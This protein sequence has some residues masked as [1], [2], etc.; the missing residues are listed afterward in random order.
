MAEPTLKFNNVKTALNSRNSKGATNYQSKKYPTAY[1]L[2][3]TLAELPDSLSDNALIFTTD[4]AELFVG[5][6]S[7]I[8]RLKLGTE[9]DLNPR[10]YL[11]ILE[12]KEIYK[13]KLEAEQ[14][15]AELQSLIQ[16]LKDSVYSKADID[17]FITKD[18]DLDGVIDKLN[19]Y[20]VEK[21]NQLLEQE[22]SRA[23]V[24]TQTQV[25][26]KVD[27]AKQEASDAVAALK[28]EVAETYA[29]IADAA[30]KTELSD[31]EVEIKDFVADKYLNKED[32]AATYSTIEEVNNLKDS[33]YT[34]A[35]IDEKLAEVNEGINSNLTEINNI[36]ISYVKQDAYDTDKASLDSS[37]E[38]LNS[39]LN[40]LDSNTYKK[41][42]IDKK[43]STINTE[44]R[45]LDSKKVNVETYDSEKSVLQNDIVTLDGNIRVLADAVYSKEEVDE[46][47][48]TLNSRIN[49][50]SQSVTAANNKIDNKVA[51]LNTAIQ[52]A[53]ATADDAA[54]QAY[55]DQELDKKADSQDVYRKT[56][57]DT[58][59]NNKANAI[60][61]VISDN[62][63]VGLNSDVS[64]TGLTSVQK[65]GAY[66]KAINAQKADKAELTSASDSINSSINA[67]GQRVTALEEKE[68]YTKAEVDEAINTA[69]VN[70]LQQIREE[71]R[72]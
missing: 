44:L 62:I 25:N 7:G 15:K 56:E 69:I 27:E 42:D 63:E 66:I 58:N 18:I 13:N 39:N 3:T 60:Y 54:P 32:A 38:N 12:A 16:E 10:L 41:S 48:A 47:E 35:Y 28:A 5:T 36:K 43:I 26:E 51:E 21:I 65:V 57:A 59:L 70:V 64:T 68:V 9:A 33:V 72:I 23:D 55:V 49:G 6:G 1:I 31:K 17:D 37:I 29:T 67:L 45:N 8:Q 22:A 24:Y 4:T 61:D 19:L 52:A 14:D 30:T 53:Q 11:K 40:T 20:T 34:S 46:K 2:Y 71:F 50:L